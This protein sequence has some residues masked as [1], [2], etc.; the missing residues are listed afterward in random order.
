MLL[1]LSRIRHWFILILTVSYLFLF[2]I[3]GLHSG[4]GLSAH[5]TDFH[6]LVSFIVF[7]NKMFCRFFVLILY[8]YFYIF[9]AF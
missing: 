9:G 2:F 6:L 8:I 4:G 5:V 3:T 7:V 1:V